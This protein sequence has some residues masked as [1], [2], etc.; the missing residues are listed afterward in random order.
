[1]EAQP[2]LVRLLRSLP[3][4]D[5]V[6]ARGEA[7]PRFDLH[8]PMLSMPLALGTTLATVPGV[9]PYL[10]AEAAQ[11][12]AWGEHLAALGA[13]LLVG[14]SRKSLIGKVLGRP[15]FERLYGGLGLASWAVSMGARVVRTHD[16]AA[17]R[18]A[19]R[20]VSAVMEGT[21]N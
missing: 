19:I 18:D 21:V 7:L 10:H 14:L 2:P 17:T 11:I 1:V 6:V 20:M 16:V 15:T 3:G 4:V 5:Q 13:P 8:C 9:V 12:A